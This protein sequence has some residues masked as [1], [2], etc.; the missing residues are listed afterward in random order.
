MPGTRWPPSHTALA[1][2]PAIALDLETTGLDVADGRVVQIG[3]VAM[4]G[5]VVLSEP[6][7]DTHV[8]PGI[9][10]PATSTRIHGITDADVADAPRFHKLIGLTGGSI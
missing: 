9:P 3:A 7:I 5:P 8:D 6:R 2:L 1:A 4:R 10:I